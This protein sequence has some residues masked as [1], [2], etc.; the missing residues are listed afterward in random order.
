MADDVELINGARE[1]FIDN[2]GRKF[3]NSQRETLESFA[4]GQN[5]F[6][7]QRRPKSFQYRIKLKV[8]PIKH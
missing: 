4:N 6:L 2:Q 7:F 8:N 5:V 1:N 3:K